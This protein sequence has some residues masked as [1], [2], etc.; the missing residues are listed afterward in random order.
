M[1]NVSFKLRSVA[2]HLVYS[3]SG[4]MAP[5]ARV[6]HKRLT[7]LIAEKTNEDYCDIISTVRTKLSFALLK[8]VLVSVRGSR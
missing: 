4:G 7:E 1:N 5:Q 3:T 2:L 8:S 6:F